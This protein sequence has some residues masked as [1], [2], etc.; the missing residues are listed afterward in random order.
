MEEPREA[1]GKM[2]NALPGCEKNIL[3]LLR[4]RKRTKTAQLDHA[5]S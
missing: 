1:Y 3:N 5:K 2:A 4:A